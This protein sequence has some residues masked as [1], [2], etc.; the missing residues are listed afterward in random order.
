MR[1]L[2]T[3]GSG[4][5]GW[6]LVKR[7]RAAG[8][9]VAYTY[10][11]TDRER[12]TESGATA[13]ALDVRDP[14]RVDAVVQRW[15]PDAVV[16]AAAMTDVDECECYPDRA[17]AVNVDGTKHVVAAAEGVGAHLLFFSTG[18]VF[19]GDGETFTEA[20]PRS[21]VNYYGQT[22]IDAEDAIVDSPVD[23]T[24]CRIDQPYCWPTPWQT[25]PFV[26]WVLNRCENGTSFPVFT[27][28]YN[29]PVYVP[30]CNETVLELLE[31]RTTGVYHVCGPDYVDRYT[32]A[33]SIAEEFG[34]N[35]ALVERSQ[36]VEAN[37]S[38]RRPNNHLSNEAVKRAIDASFRSI[39]AALARM[40]KRRRD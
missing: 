13:L 26:S 19:D 32:W 8:H 10:H 29:T 11:E 12:D 28:W 35:T 27:D 2:I 40:A 33:R 39:D 9:E 24:V 7:A 38:A 3:G 17:R 25:K 34:Y 22:K 4:L 23:A 16:H 36:S 18:F 37:L 21:A 6:D 31:T 30:D 5:V 15:E 1:L 14:D 20:D